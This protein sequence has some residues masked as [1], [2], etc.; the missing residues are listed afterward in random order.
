MK[1]LT[2]V[3]LAVILAC[4][5]FGNND[6]KTPQPYNP[7]NTTG[8]GFPKEL[9]DIVHCPN[10]FSN[11]DCKH[12]YRPAV[13]PNNG[14]MWFAVAYDGTVCPIW[15]PQTTMASLYQDFIC[16]WRTPV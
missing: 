10:V 13:D 5:S 11:P 4:A 7:W 2:V 6:Y 8:E 14:D 1:T 12:W 3:L 9:V 15:P 16:R